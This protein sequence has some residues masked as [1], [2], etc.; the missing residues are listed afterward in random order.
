MNL[1]KLRTLS[2]FA[3]TF[4]SAFSEADTPRDSD[5]AVPP[6]PL[7]VSYS[8]DG[9]ISEREIPWKSLT[10]LPSHT[11]MLTLEIDDQDRMMT[12]VYFKDFAKKFGDS[13]GID[14][15]LAN[16]SDGY[17]S[18]FTPEVIDAANPYIVL[19]VDGKPL[20]TWL[21]EIGHPEWGPFII[22]TDDP[23]VLRDPGHKNPWGVTELI[24]TRYHEAVATLP[25][26][27]R[28]QG[29]SLGL[30]IYLNACVSCHDMPDS[31]F[32]G[33]VSTRATPTLG[34][35]AKHSTPYFENMLIE[36]SATNPLAKKMPSYRHY[37]DDEKRS[38]RELLSSL[39]E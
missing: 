28:D 34:L 3:L 31:I 25:A 17:Q 2:L 21:A 11:S 13:E 36:P 19:K 10:E 9:E 37:N 30:D 32:G 14:L 6:P 7:V 29:N 8:L 18:N 27:F 4:S 38:I 1:F 22:N 20:A 26:S 23:S 12:F 16:C 35:F 39:A 5:T 33:Q 24:A 15:W